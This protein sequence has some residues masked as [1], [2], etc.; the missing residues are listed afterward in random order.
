MNKLKARWGI[1][2]NWQ[3]VIIFIVFAIT[4]STSAKLAEPLCNLLGIYEAS[5]HWAVYWSARIFLIF[6]IY[7]VL[8]V[9]FG[10]IFGQFQFFWAFEKK[11]LRRIGFAKLLQ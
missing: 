9:S 3:I 4:G 1:D 8:L 11:M 5:S 6:P 2:S 10:W 7:Q